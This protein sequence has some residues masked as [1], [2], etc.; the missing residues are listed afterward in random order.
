VNETWPH[1]AQPG[2]DGNAQDVLYG[3]RGAE[4]VLLGEYRDERWTVA[5]GWIAGDALTNIR[6]WTFAAP[7]AFAGQV[8][9]LVLEATNDSAVAREAGSD[10]LRWAEMTPSQPRA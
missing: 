4:I 2:D 1:P 7:S 8:R 5:R 6:R 9:R 10:A 3:W